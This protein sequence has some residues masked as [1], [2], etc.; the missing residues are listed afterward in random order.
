V[1]LDKRFLLEKIGTVTA[2][3]V[4]EILQGVLKLLQPRLVDL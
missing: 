3:R 1:T 2:A 4:R